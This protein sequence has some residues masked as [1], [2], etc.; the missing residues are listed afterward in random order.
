[1]HQAKLLKIMRC[2]VIEVVDVLLMYF[3]F[4]RP[5]RVGYS[6]QSAV[7]V[8]SNLLM[9]QPT[10]SILTMFPFFLMFFFQ[11]LTDEAIDIVFD[12]INQAPEPGVITDSN[13]YVASLGGKLKE[14]S[15]ESSPYPFRQAE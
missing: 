12:G 4:W 2:V 9:P 5:V 6:R 7:V 15:A 3:T 14:I 11:E 8:F 10:I 1:M 13:I